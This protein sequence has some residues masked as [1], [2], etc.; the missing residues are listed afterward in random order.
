M[1]FIG[2]AASCTI[3]FVE[4]YPFTCCTQEEP[5]RSFFR[6]T[7]T[8]VPLP[9]VGMTLF[10]REIAAGKAT[11]QKRRMLYGMTRFISAVDLFGGGRFVRCCHHFFLLFCFPLAYLFSFTANVAER[12]EFLLVIGTDVKSAQF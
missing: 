9:D 3:S 6:E 8:Q 2:A 7:H 5:D 1:L 11:K 10:P 4:N 12:V